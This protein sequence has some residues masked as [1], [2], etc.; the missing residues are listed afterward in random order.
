VRPRSHALRGLLTWACLGLGAA[1][2]FETGDT[3]TSAQADHFQYVGEARFSPPAAFTVSLV[4]DAE[5]TAYAA[6]T[7]VSDSGRVAVM[8]YS[9]SSRRWEKIGG[10]GLSRGG[11]YMLDLAMGPAGIPYLAFKDEGDSMR[12]T[13]LRWEP[14]SLRW[15]RVGR[16]ATTPPET[17]EFAFAMG[18][19]GELYLAY[20]D[21]RHELRSTVL[22]YDPAGNAWNAVGDSGFTD[23]EGN[24]L[25]MAVDVAGVPYLGYYDEL[26]AGRA[27]AMRYAGLSEGWTQVGELGFSRAKANGT[28]MAIDSGGMPY[29]GYIDGFENTFKATVRRF[30]SGTWTPLGDE[31]FSSGQPL[32]LNLAVSPDGAP[33]VA[34]SNYDQGSALNMLRWDDS[35]QAWQDEG[36][37]SLTSAKGRAV[38]LAFGPKGE[39][40]I[41]FLDNDDGRLSVMRLS[42]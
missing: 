29:L 6:F 9:P 13:V 31:C 36:G 23:A 27:S 20:K 41:A 24:F 26:R 8:R 12:V 5:G 11:V 25:T 16:N 1:C 14:D 2:M 35:A 34:F 39:P 17:S 38:A 40:W 15:M 22:R 42:E 4:V 37:S 18:P 3:R 21:G 19:A 32:S 30:A 7:D 10:G 28:V 33:H